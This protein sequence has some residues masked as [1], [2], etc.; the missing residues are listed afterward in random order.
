[1]KT[2]KKVLNSSLQGNVCRWRSQHPNRYVM[3]LIVSSFYRLNNKRE[4]EKASQY[5]IAMDYKNILSSINESWLS[6]RVLLSKD[7]I[8]HMSDKD[9]F[10]GKI[11]GFL[12]RA[13]YKRKDLIVTGEIVY[14]LAF[15][16]W[17]NDRRCR[18]FWFAKT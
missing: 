12:T 6:K 3:V 1:M 14:C 15:K 7:E 4:K 18:Y 9:S 16:S 11:H 2:H 5:H 10:R 8:R 13:Y 17:S